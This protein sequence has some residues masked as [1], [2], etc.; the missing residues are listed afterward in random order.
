MVEELFVGA[1]GWDVG[2]KGNDDGRGAFT[3]EQ[4]VRPVDL[5]Q[6]R[7][8]S[9]DLWGYQFLRQTNINNSNNI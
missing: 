3:T 2:K 6:F 1:T 9:A 7:V 8:V 4:R 5:E